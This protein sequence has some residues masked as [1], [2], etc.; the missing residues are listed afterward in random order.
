MEH[1]KPS[2][3]LKT[4]IEAFKVEVNQ[5]KQKGIEILPSVD[6]P[7]AYNS[8]TGVVVGRKGSDGYRN[9]V[10]LLGD[11]KELADL[12]AEAGYGFIESTEDIQAIAKDYLSESDGVTGMVVLEL[13][14]EF[15]EIWLTHSARP[16][17]KGAGYSLAFVAAHKA[18]PKSPGI[19]L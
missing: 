16:F 9:A 5:A 4:R 15:K 1:E 7:Y 11:G 12:Q 17:E 8:V 19:S 10:K 13:N 14:G 18:K 6:G 2:N 3:P